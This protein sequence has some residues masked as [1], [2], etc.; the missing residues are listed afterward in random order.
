MSSGGLYAVF[1]GEGYYVGETSVFEVRFADHADPDKGNIEFSSAKKQAVATGVE[2]EPVIIL[3]VPS[4][5]PSTLFHVFETFVNSRAR[6]TSPPNLNRNLWA[7]RF[8][9]DHIVHSGE[10]IEKLMVE[11]KNRLDSGKR[12]PIDGRGDWHAAFGDIFTNPITDDYISKIVR[13]KERKRVGDFYKAKIGLTIGVDAYEG[14][15]RGEGYDE[16]GKTKV[17]T[18]QKEA[19]EKLRKRYSAEAEEAR[20]AEYGIGTKKQKK[21]LR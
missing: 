11:V 15:I 4:S 8:H 21:R 7:T 1:V 16:V 20:F 13:G 9:K 19:A 18:V 12:L 2:I 6:A 3:P 10:E 14:R 5:M 17:K